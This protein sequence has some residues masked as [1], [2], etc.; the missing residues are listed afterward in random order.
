[1]LLQIDKLGKV[2]VTVEENYWSLEKDYDKI[3][4]DLTARIEALEAQ[5]AEKEEAPKIV[6]KTKKVIEAKKTEPVQKANYFDLSGR[7]PITGL[8]K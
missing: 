8:R 5:L 6:K 4:A 7:D 3:I 2:A 1:M